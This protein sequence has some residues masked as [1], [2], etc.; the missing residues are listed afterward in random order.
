MECT[1]ECS[2]FDLFYLASLAQ[3]LS[4]CGI[5]HNPAISDKLSNLRLSSVS[6]L[7]NLY[8]DIW[9]QLHQYVASP[10]DNA[11]MFIVKFKSLSPPS[12]SSMGLH[13]ECFGPVHLSV[14]GCYRREAGPEDEQQLSAWRAL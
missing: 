1:S 11:E 3:L 9:M 5:K 8:V 13:P 12:G 10:E 7:E 14:S 6:G 2:I 4:I